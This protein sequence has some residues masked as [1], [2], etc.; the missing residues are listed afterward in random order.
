MC[1]ETLG[2]DITWRNNKLDFEYNSLHNSIEDLYC[3]P[4]GITILEQFRWNRLIF[5]GSAWNDFRINDT[6]ISL[7][8][9]QRSQLRKVLLRSLCVSRKNQLIHGGSCLLSILASEQE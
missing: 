1:T 9:G 4:V 6:K 2:Y 5:F 3:R 7:S 8:H